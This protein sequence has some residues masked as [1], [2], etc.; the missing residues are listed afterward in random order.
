MVT[1]N[2]ENPFETALKIQL[3]RTLTEGVLIDIKLKILLIQNQ[4]N[5]K[6][7]SRI[8]S[9]LKIIKLRGHNGN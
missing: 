9:K 8:L 1:S 2:K 5:R 7:L 4:K 3:L 6:K